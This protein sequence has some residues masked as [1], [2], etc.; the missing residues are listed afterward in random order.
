MASTE[1]ITTASQLLEATGLGRCE[2]RRG[3]LVMMSPAGFEHGRIVSRINARL[4]IFVD[5]HRLG[6]VTGAETGFLIAREPDTVRAPDV[7]FVRKERLGE[8]TGAGYFPGPPDLAVEVVSPNDS[9]SEV[10]TKAH[11]WL[12]AGCVEVWA[13]DPQTQMVTIYRDKHATEV[14]GTHETLSSEGLL[15]GFSARIDEIFRQ[16]S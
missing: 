5:E 9:A 2:L 15:P 12:M 16:P 1:Q 11:E 13:V 7:G 3:E 14:L 4:E 6:V 8:H 10:L